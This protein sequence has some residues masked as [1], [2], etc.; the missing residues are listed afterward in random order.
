MIRPILTMAAMFAGALAI[1]SLMA[2]TLENWA[3]TRHDADPS[4]LVA[5]QPLTMHSVTTAGFAP[6]A[7]R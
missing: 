3:V 4:S 1:V 5:A 7:S 6:S 2:T